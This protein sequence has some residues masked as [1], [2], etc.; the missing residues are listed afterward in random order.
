MSGINERIL[1]NEI[2]NDEI[3]KKLNDDISE[4]T[5]Q[6]WDCDPVSIQYIRGKINSNIELMNFLK[7]EIIVAFK[8]GEQEVKV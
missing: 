6:L 2:N 7:K 8:I 1:G 4:L 5:Y 3:A